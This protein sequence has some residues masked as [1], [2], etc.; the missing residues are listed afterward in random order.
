MSRYT[1]VLIVLKD[2]STHSDYN[3]RII[4]YLN[5]RHTAI[6]D[7]MFAVTIDVADDSNIN[8]YV[9]EGIESIPALRVSGDESFTYGVNSILAALA[10]LEIAPTP[11]PEHSSHIQSNDTY[12][13]KSSAFYQMALKEMN[14][15]D[16]EDP[17]APSTLKAYHQD[18]PEAPLNDKSIEEKTKA[19]TRIYEDR[20]KRCASKS[21]PSKHVSR[22]VKPTPQSG[23]VD[24]D[25]FIQS[26]GFD[27]GEELLM[28][29]IAQNL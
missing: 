13:D 26:G 7:N 17:D 18:T 2:A 14:C 4:E 12:D 9:R 3:K 23:R 28:R 5:D 29:Q 10:R 19:Y 6:N 15:D 21:T 8:D 20:R 27:K 25:R 22:A 11:Q 16:Q 24:V 1:K